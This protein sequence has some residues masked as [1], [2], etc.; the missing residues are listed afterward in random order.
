VLIILTLTRINGIFVF[1]MNTIINF[2]KDI[3]ADILTFIISVKAYFLSF[4]YNMDAGT[5]ATL[6]FGII[7]GVPFIAMIVY[8][9]VLHRR[10]KKMGVIYDSPKEI[11]DEFWESAHQDFYLAPMYHGM[12]GNLFN[13]ADNDPQNPEYR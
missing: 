12:T 2:L 13:Y 1:N 7:F 10:G 6:M 8:A 4:I 5:L 11:D 3:D 9:V